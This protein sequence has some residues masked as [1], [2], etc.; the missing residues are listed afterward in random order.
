MNAV[1]MAEEFVKRYPA[2][3]TEDKEFWTS[4]IASLLV[5]YFEAKAKEVFLGTK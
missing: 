1:E 5:D 3:F 4:T 2:M